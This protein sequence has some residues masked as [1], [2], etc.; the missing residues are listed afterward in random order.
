MHTFPPRPKA[1]R[2]DEDMMWVDIE[3]GRTLGIP[4]SWFPRLF[5][6][7]PEQRMAFFLSPSG[8]HWDEIDEDISIGGLLAG[9]G[10]MTHPVQQA[11][12]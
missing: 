4:L 12:E 5:R 2:F 7:T 1:V 11:A 6:A 9:Y 8:I 10:D 3:D